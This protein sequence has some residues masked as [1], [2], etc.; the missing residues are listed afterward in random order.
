MNK[1]PDGPTI[2]IVLVIWL[3]GISILHGTHSH[4][5]VSHPAP[6]Q[7]G[8]CD[9]MFADVAETVPDLQDILD[10]CDWDTDG[11]VLALRKLNRLPPPAGLKA[12]SLKPYVMGRPAKAVTLEIDVFFF[13]LQS[14]PHPLA[15][16][17]LEQLIERMSSGYEIQSIEVVGY[18]DIDEHQE[19]KHMALDSKRA[20][21]IRA[22]FIAVG[23]PPERIRT[24]INFP[25]HENTA[26][27]RARDRSVAIKVHLLSQDQSYVEKVRASIQ[28]IIFYGSLSGNPVATVEFTTAETGAIIERRLIRSSGNRHWDE[29][30]ERA[31]QKTDVIPADI[32]GRVPNKLEI[33]FF[34]KSRK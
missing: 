15:F 18:S 3:V 13:L 6:K 11:F 24:N 17:K 22:Y 34:P 16:P 33:S 10:R 21:F 27:G 26:L 30:V 23:V 19:M 7:A 12:I 9:R 20:E 5:Q 1:K 4:A 31:V 25:Q 2:P 29:A 14:Y 28:P 32:D 8:I